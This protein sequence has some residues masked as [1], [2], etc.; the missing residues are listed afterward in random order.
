[1]RDFNDAF[2]L[3]MGHEGGY[4]NNPADPG[5]ETM[6]GITARVARA[7]GYTGPMRDLP[8]DTAKA[9]AKAWY[10]DP[11]GCD[12]Y[13]IRVAWQIFDCAYNGGRVVLW[14]QQAAG[15]AADGQLG[16]KSRAALAAVNPHRFVLWFLAVRLMYMTGLKIWPSFGKGWARRISTNMIEGAKA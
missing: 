8:R 11:F 1:M 13:D 15:V 9:I 6:F 4:S 10:W 16:P 7:F 3:L 5:G 14:A 2:E 12:Q